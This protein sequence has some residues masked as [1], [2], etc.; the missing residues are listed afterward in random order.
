MKIGS[1]FSGTGGL[2]IAV[3]QVTGAKPAWF[4]EWDESPSKILAHHWPQVPN[5]RD[6]TKVDWSQVEPVD[7]ITGGYPCQPFSQAGQRKGTNDDRHLWPYI[8]QAIRVLRPR[9]AVFENVAGHLTLG[10]GTVLSDLAEIG[11]DAEWT[12]LRA[13]DIGAPHHRERLFILAY[14]HGQRPQA[15][16]FP[17]GSAQEVPRDYHGISSLA[18]VGSASDILREAALRWGDTAERVLIWSVLHGDPP[19]V[20][21]DQVTY[22]DPDLWG[23]RFPE[24][25]PGVNPEYVEWSMGLPAGHVTAPGIGLTRAEQLKALG[26]GVVPQQAVAALVDLLGCDCHVSKQVL[27]CA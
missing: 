23:T 21:V 18:G 19:P 27:K 6:V 4:C 9:Y 5:L 3:E 14:P 12:T 2:D 26:N 13:S 20:I 10:F 15:E 11:W 17:S 24:V 7:I 25:K 8:L 16:R 22:H 1:M